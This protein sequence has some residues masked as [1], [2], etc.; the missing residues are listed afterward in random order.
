ML[1]GD[2]PG[3][4]IFP[5]G[6]SVDPHSMQLESFSNATQPSLVMDGNIFALPSSPNIA[7]DSSSFST[8]DTYGCLSNAL[9]D[10]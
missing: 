3:E 9:P 10:W 5:W 1:T 8:L 6:E 7:L 2:F 4:Q